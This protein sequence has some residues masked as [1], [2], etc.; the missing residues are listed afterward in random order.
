MEVRYP[1][2]RAVAWKMALVSALLVG[3]IIVPFAV[4]LGVSMSR[5]TPGTGFLPVAGAV[6]A[7]GLTAYVAV[8]IVRRLGRHSLIVTEHGLAHMY[9]SYQVWVRWPDFQGVERT[10]SGEMLVFRAGQMFG[11]NGAIRPAIQQRYQQL[12]MDR[13][14]LVSRYVPDWRDGAIGQVL[15]DRGVT[16]PGPGH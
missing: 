1:L 3:A 10:R 15:R 5:G 7:L 13:R 16:V 4:L 2:R 9:G 6:L 11:V 8:G 12:G 14:I